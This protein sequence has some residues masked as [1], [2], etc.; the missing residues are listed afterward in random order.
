MQA[1][2]ARYLE[3]QAAAKKRSETEKSTTNSP[4]AASPTAHPAKSLLTLLLNGHYVLL[5]LGI[6]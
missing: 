4:T 2:A 6:K 5:S 1:L 3:R